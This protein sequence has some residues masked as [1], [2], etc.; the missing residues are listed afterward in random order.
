MTPCQP[1]RSTRSDRHASRLRSRVRPGQDQ[2]PFAR[3]RTDRY[4]VASDRFGAGLRGPLRCR[5][6]HARPR[7]V[8]DRVRS[9]G[10]GGAFPRR[11][12]LR[13][14]GS[15]GTAGARRRHR[16]CGPASGEAHSARSRSGG[17]Y[18]RRRRGPAGA[19]PALGGQPPGC[20]D[21]GGR[22]DA[23]LGWARMSGIAALLG[24]RVWRRPDADARTVRSPG[25]RLARG[26]IGD[27]ARLCRLARAGFPPGAQA[28]HIRAAA[29]RPHHE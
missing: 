20:G 10:R 22:R 17:R 23:W 24:G 8:A 5:A 15:I 16:R 11:C 4:R 14:A 18:G 3:A 2:P 9:A 7:P 28:W 27:G 13:V 29:R 26:R 19:G 1:A 21:A 12:Q 6:G 25:P